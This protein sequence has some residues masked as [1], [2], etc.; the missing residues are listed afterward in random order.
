[1]MGALGYGKASTA[2]LILFM[3]SIFVVESWL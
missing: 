1:M 2:I 3:R